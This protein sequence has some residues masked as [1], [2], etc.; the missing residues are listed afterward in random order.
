MTIV[1]NY[2]APAYN[3]W[4]AGFAIMS[5]LDWD[6]AVTPISKKIGTLLPAEPWSLGGVASPAS[7]KTWPN[8]YHRIHES[9]QYNKHPMQVGPRSQE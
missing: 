1:V 2:S 4:N 6:C 3:R 9:I 5:A 8:Q 7:G